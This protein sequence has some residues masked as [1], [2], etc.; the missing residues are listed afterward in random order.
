MMAQMQAHLR[1]IQGAGAD[2]MQAMLSM[3]RPMVANMISQMND[4]MRG[5]HMPAD[6]RWTATADSLRQDLVRMPKMGGA[7]GRRTWGASRG[8]WT[9]TAR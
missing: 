4:E 8:S 2:S 3:H 1:T 5:M 9:C 7:G 6:A